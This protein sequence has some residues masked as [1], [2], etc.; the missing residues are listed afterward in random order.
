LKG[1]FALIYGLAYW[2][3][4]LFFFV[5][6]PIVILWISVIVDVF[7][8]KDMG[9]WAK[10]GWTILVFAVPLLGSL[11]YLAVRPSTEISA[12]QR[13]YKRAA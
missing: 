4:L 6:V 9:G 1:G 10:L 12:E 7:A 2:N 5:Y 11:I 8:R 3:W 13:Q